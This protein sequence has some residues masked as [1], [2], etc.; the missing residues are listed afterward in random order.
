MCCWNAKVVLSELWMQ[1]GDSAVTHLSCVC[2]SL[3]SHRHQV[4]VQCLSNLQTVNRSPDP[5]DR[6]GGCVGARLHPFLFLKY[7]REFSLFCLTKYWFL[8]PIV[9]FVTAKPAPESLLGLLSLMLEGDY[10]FFFATP[11]S[12]KHPTPNKNI[13]LSCRNS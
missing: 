11:G 13:Y 3:S 2:L 5:S 4:S 8:I 1:R 10:L 7:N 12:R 9:D 6:Q